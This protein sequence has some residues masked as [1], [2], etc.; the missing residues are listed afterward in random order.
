[1]TNDELN[2]TPE[3]SFSLD[4]I[5]SEFKDAPLS[6]SEGES[7]LFEDFLIDSPSQKKPE[8]AIGDLSSFQGDILSGEKEAPAAFVESAAAPKKSPEDHFSP[9][10]W[11]LSIS[12][13]ESPDLF[14][15][16]S[17]SFE[18]D[19]ASYEEKAGDA[20]VSQD[21]EPVFA[22]HEPIFTAE[23]EPSLKNALG[24]DEDLSASEIFSR[25]PREEFASP[26]DY[27]KSKYYNRDTRQ[28]PD[29]REKFLAPILGLLAYSA[30]KRRKKQAARPKQEEQTPELRPGKAAEFYAAQ[31]QS[32][33]LRCLVSSALTMVLVYLSYGLPAMG[34][35]GSSPSI[36]SLVCLVLELGVMI[37]GLDI[38]ANGAAALRRGSPSLDSLVFVSGVVTALDALVIALTGN[39]KVG[40]P[41][42]GASALA[43]TVSLWGNMLSCRAYALSFSTAASAKDPNLVLSISGIDHEGCVLHKTQRGPRGFV[44][45]TETA[46]L[47]ENTY[48]AFAPILLIG[49]L[50]LSLFCFIGSKG[51]ADFMHTLA[52]CMASTA[53]LSAVLGFS[54]PFYILAKRLARSG[55]AVAGYAGAAELGRLRR[56][57]ITD[58][59][60][61]P[62]RTLSI[63]D[64]AIVQGAHPDTVISC[65]GSVIAAGGLGLAPVF[66]ELMR[67]NGCVMRQVEDFACHEGGG[68]IARVGG[69]Q[70]YL[71]TSGFLQLMGVRVPKSQQTTSNAVFVAIN[72]TL[73]GIFTMNYKPVATVQRALVSL[74]RCGIDP[75]FAV[76]D[77]NITPLMIK[78]KFRLP[79][80]SYDF[81]SF[82]DRYRISSREENDPG[83]VAAL[84]ARGGLNSVAGLVT[85]CR[86]LYNISRISLLLSVISSVFLPVLMLCLCWTGSYDSASCGNLITFMLLWL[87]PVAI[88]SY[89]LRR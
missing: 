29:I 46:D 26:D 75:L 10:F 7:P 58:S 70:V 34:L 73:S 1:M 15:E 30:E 25:E 79:S 77:F 53:S 31:A 56:V 8:P 21:T 51:R 60:I 13:H 83:V 69:D 67:K 27:T 76:R 22:V 18:A 68:L 47:F 86:K 62:L 81:P 43:V 24:L 89:G 65:A 74:L 66:T 32:L 9:E 54:L 82:A 6:P 80:K 85:R 45:T 33:W 84:F 52:A 20:P 64:V 14:G 5:L 59:D 39:I 57:M 28:A 12:D 88:M 2:F 38:M 44:R 37:I 41:F 78:Q 19:S 11:D 3:E 40:T 50:I 61:F 42:C 4:S 17:I 87:A 36:R 23:D 35:L 49:S 55:A 63:A 72:G 48:R 71:G 16:L